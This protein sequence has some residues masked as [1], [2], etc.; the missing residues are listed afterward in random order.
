MNWII[1]R[2][3][4]WWLHSGRYPWS[5]FHRRFFEQKYLANSLPSVNSLE[6]IA[7]VLQQIQWT[8]DRAGLL[9]DCISYPQTTWTTR[10]DDCDGFAV[11]AAALLIRLDRDFRPVLLTVVVQP[12]SESHTVCV[13]ERQD[14]LGCFSNAVLDLEGSASRLEVAQKYSGGKKRLVCWDVRDPHDFTLIEFHTA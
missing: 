14:R 4:V 2:F 12:V 3:L 5:R 10:Q 1:D 11:L 7:L 8:A 9:W 6:E 13:F